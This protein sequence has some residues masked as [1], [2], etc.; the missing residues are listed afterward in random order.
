L[1]IWLFLEELPTSTDG[2]PPLFFILQVLPLEL[3][4]TSFGTSSTFVGNAGIFGKV[5]FPRLVT[6]FQLL[7]QIL[8]V[9]STVSF[10]SSYGLIIAKGNTSKHLD[11]CNSFSYYIDGFLLRSRNDIFTYTKYKDSVCF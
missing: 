11:S 4:F 3:F 2:A 9:W 5:Y 1:F 10:I 8:C 7:S 6:P